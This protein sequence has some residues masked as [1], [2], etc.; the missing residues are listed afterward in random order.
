MWT[1]NVFPSEFYLRNSHG[2]P[3]FAVAFLVPCLGPVATH[4]DQMPTVC[5]AVWTQCSAR[6]TRPLSAHSLTE[7][8]VVKQVRDMC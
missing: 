2:I 3:E 1:R 6:Q 5:Q 7:K 4:I 8:S